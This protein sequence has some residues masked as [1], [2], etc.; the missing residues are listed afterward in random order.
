MEDRLEKVLSV[1]E[2]RV[3]VKASKYLTYLIFAGLVVWGL[4]SLLTFV[5]EKMD[6]L[7]NRF[8][9]EVTTIN[10]NLK[11]LSLPDFFQIV[12]V[13]VVYMVGMAGIALLGSLPIVLVARFGIDAS[14][15]GKTED[16]LTSV[17]NTMIDAK[18]EM[19][20]A[21]SEVI[22]K[23]IL[24]ITNLQ[25]EPSLFRKIQLALKPNRKKNKKLTKQEK[26]EL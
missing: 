9:F 4:L 10:L 25:K 26:M 14:Q 1:I 18:K 6:W 12:F 16:L 13:L 24:S 3:G 2:R 5:I 11:L 20:L 15:R 17:K 19:P 22:E 7:G 23:V 8:N 21:Q